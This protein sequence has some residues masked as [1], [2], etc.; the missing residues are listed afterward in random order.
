M[1]EGAPFGCALKHI[2]NKKITYLPT[3]NL[4]TL[5]SN[6]MKKLDANIAQICF[7]THFPRKKISYF[8]IFNICPMQ[9]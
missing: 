1:F 9:E 2:K 8:V 3:N 7:I 5:K 4:S 6:T